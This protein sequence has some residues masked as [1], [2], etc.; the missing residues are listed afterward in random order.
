MMGVTPHL[1]IITDLSKFARVT[2]STFFMIQK[3]KTL[4]QS[5]F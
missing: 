4:S 1:L 5:I 2:Q 3:L